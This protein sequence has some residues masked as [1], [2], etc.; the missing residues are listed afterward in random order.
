MCLVTSKIFVRSKDKGA[1]VV[2]SCISISFILF[3]IVF[4]FLFLAIIFFF[5][6]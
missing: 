5:L 3:N 1:S 6:K 4:H 2:L